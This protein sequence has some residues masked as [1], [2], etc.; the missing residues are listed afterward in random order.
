MNMPSEATTAMF[1][2][3]LDVAGAGDGE[4]E[5]ELQEARRR[6]RKLTEIDRDPATRT[7]VRLVSPGCA[8][9]CAP[10]F[11]ACAVNRIKLSWWQNELASL[12]EARS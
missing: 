2:S 3:W 12:S 8:L 9:G 1:R 7:G 4:N 5:S 10:C 6:A 11:R